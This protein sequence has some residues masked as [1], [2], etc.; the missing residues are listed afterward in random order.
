MNI[1]SVGRDIVSKARIPVLASYKM[2]AY[3]ALDGSL[4]YPVEIYSVASKNLCAAHKT[5]S[6]EIMLYTTSLY[7]NPDVCA[8]KCSE[9]CDD[10]NTIYNTLKSITRRENNANA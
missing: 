5:I 1:T 8:K 9:L 7:A 2:L 6:G 3:E 10:Y 4:F